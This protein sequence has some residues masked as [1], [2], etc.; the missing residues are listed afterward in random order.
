MLPAKFPSE[1]KSKFVGF[2]D[3]SP[4][5]LSLSVKETFNLDGS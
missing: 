3:W 5:H 4:G 2:L 1:T